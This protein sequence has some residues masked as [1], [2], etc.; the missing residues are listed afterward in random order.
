MRSFL[1]G[2]LLLIVSTASAVEKVQYSVAFM[3]PGTKTPATNVKVGQEFDVVV[4]VRDLRPDGNWVNAAGQTRPLIRGVF[5]G[6]CDLR[7]D[8][9]ICSEVSIA[10]NATY[11]NG[12]EYHGSPGA[13]IDNTGA[14]AAALDGL[15][16]SARELFRVRMKAKETGSVSFRLGFDVP[17]PQQ[18]TLVYGNIGADPPEQS[19]VDP[20]TEIK[21]V[22]ATMVIKTLFF[23]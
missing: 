3:L 19:Y 4:S 11:P 8:T 9:S 5:A 2:L 15:G 23:K 12:K 22:N 13:G 1:F 16:T 21:S 17:R 10:F 14:F 6:Y 20:A 18:N 7:Y